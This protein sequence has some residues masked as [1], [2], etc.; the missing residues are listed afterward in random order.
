MLTL[1]YAA[2]T[3]ARAS[4]IALA[5]SGAQYRIVPLSFGQGEQR[6]PEYLAINPKGR[7]P[8]LATGRVF[9]P[10]VVM[11]TVAGVLN[12]AESLTTRLAV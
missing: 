7:V 10:V 6:K 12:K 1:Y 11:V 5:E 2:N 3:C 9:P 8:A 4:L